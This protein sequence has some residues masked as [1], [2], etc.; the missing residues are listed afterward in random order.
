IF[1]E[2]DQIDSLRQDVNAFVLIAA[3]P[4]DAL[5]LRARVRW[6]WDDIADNARQEHS[7]W[8]YLEA[9][10]KIRSWAVPSLRYD[11]YQYLDDREST[12]L[13]R[14]NPEHWIRFQFESRF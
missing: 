3:R 5:R 6:Y 12:L 2:L 1:D 13:R 14:P 8:A 4:T 9:Q 7:V 10:Y 11:I